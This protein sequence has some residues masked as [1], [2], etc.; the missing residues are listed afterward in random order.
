MDSSAGRL[1]S[2]SAG[3]GG[4]TRRLVD[5]LDKVQ[6]AERE[7]EA[8]SQLGAVTG[9]TADNAVHDF[10]ESSVNSA[11]RFRVVNGAVDAAGDDRLLE[12]IVRKVGEGGSGAESKLDSLIALAKV[13]E[14]LR[15]EQRR[16]R[17]VLGGKLGELRVGERL[18]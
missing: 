6:A 9:S 16:K 12:L 17:T 10:L 14:H 3:L 15:A 7:S 1:A 8:D 18:T 11:S 13:E 4:S 2:R 5:R